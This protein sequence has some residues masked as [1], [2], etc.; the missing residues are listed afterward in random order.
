METIDFFSYEDIEL[1]C[2]F[3]KTNNVLHPRDHSVY[4]ESYL[5]LSSS[6]RQELVFR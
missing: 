2:N 6:N 4:I 5:I 1:H 3:N